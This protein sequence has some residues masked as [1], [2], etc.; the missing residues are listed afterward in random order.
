MSEWEGTGPA[1]AASFAL[2]T[3]GAVDAV[4]DAVAARVPRGDLLDVG[5]G[6][7]AL[8]AAAELRG[9]VL[10]AAEPEPTLIAVLRDVHPHVAVAPAALPHLP[11]PDGAFDAVTATFVLNHVHDPRASARELARVSRAGGAVA[12]TIWPAEASPLRPLWEAMSRVAG[13]MSPPH[14]LPPG[15]DF[16]RTPE[17]LARLLTDAGV[18]DVD[19]S[20]P[21][22]TW[23]ISP[24]ALWSGVEGGIATIGNLYRRVDPPTRRRMREVYERESAALVGTSDVL[25]LPHTAVLA[26]GTR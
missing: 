19:T 13:T 18:R 2:L 24:D 4:L 17:G 9:Y 1:Y 14:S 22:W 23:E 15:R 16:P 20:E 25:R 11:Y 3:A 5:A 21:A 10:H 12:A 26:V 8:L 7:G 6:S